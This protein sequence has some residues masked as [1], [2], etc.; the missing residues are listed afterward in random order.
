MRVA[1]LLTGL[2]VLAGAGAAGAT[3]PPLPACA[4]A[5]MHPAEGL[6]PYEVESPAEGYVLYW[7]F[8]GEAPSQVYRLVVELCRTGERMEATFAQA[9]DPARP[10]TIFDG[11]RTQVRAAFAAD[12][13][14][15]FADLAN[16]ARAAGGEGR[17]TR[18]DYESCACRQWG[19]Q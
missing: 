3:V 19:K 8:A 12:E 15:T 13:V 4:V 7:G 11:F 2:T 16:Q 10:W 17:T 9:A 18:V 1:A 14:Y 5:D 6:T